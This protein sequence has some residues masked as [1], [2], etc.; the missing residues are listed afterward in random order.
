MKVVLIDANVYLRFFDSNQRGFKKLLDFLLKIE[1]DLF[2]TSQIVEEVERNKLS[3]FGKS[4]PNYKD[5]MKLHNI[6]LP[7]HFAMDS[8]N[9]DIINWNKKRKELEN[10]NLLLNEELEA[11]LAENLKKISSSSDYVSLKL[12]SIFENKIKETEEQF[13]RAKCR[14]DTGNPPGKHSD[15]LGDQITWEQFLNRVQT[16][17]EV[18]IVSNDSDYF[19]QYDKGVFLNAFLHS[20]LLNK[21]PNLK[22]NCFSRLAEFTKGHPENV[23]GKEQLEEI[24][25]EE[26]LYNRIPITSSNI[27]S[28]GYDENSQT[29]EIEFSNGSVYQYFDVPVNIYQGMMTSSSHGQYFLQHIKGIYQYNKV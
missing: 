14:K 21:N 10:K 16:A 22:V 7:E 18:W 3:V 4:I 19:T 5:K 27:A 12:K 24:S 2:I 23:I 25:K 1:K 20:E 9:F 13:L 17:E 26:K 29:L 28:V 8:N 15:S 6:F 11:I